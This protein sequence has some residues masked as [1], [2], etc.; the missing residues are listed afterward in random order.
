MHEHEERREPWWWR[1]FA[2]AAAL[3]NEKDVDANASDLR[4][5][6]LALERYQKLLAIPKST[7]ILNVDHFV[8]S[9]LRTHR[10]IANRK[11]VQKH[12]G[13]MYEAA[14]PRFRVVRTPEVPTADATEIAVRAADL[15][16]CVHGDADMQRWLAEQITLLVQQHVRLTQEQ[17]QEEVNN[18]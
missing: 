14:Y 8:K 5:T 16:G 1:H 11:S 12:V 17:A 2:V 18:G 9:T 10:N 13:N 15:A 3:L 4:M 6:E 7:A